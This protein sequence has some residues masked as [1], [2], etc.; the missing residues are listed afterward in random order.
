MDFEIALRDKI[1]NEIMDSLDSIYC[2]FQEGNRISSQ[3]MKLMQYFRDIIDR[4]HFIKYKGQKT[5]KEIL[6][7]TD[8]FE[9]LLTD[10]NLSEMY[11]RT[12]FTEQELLYIKYVKL[13]H[14][15]RNYKNFN[16]GEKY[17]IIDILLR[18][19]ILQEFE[20]Q[21]IE[22][23][24]K[25]MEEQLT[26]GDAKMQP[27]CKHF[28]ELLSDKPYGEHL[29]QDFEQEIEKLVDRYFNDR[30]NCGGYALKIDRCIFPLGRKKSFSQSVSTI[31]DNYSFVQLLGDRKLADDEYL[32]I[33]RANKENTGHHFIRVDDD[34]IVR[35][36]DGNRS[37]KIFNGWSENLENCQEA[38]FAVKKEH[39]MFNYDELKH[40]KEG[41]NFNDT[42][43]QAIE[44]KRNNFSYHGHEFSLKKSSNEEVYVTSNGSIVANILTDGEEHLIEIAEGKEKYVENFSGSITPIIENGHLVNRSQFISQKNFDNNDER[45]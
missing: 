4:Y 9:N 29:S 13:T 31:L 18:K 32:V 34:G 10:E 11:E 30:I 6:Q 17:A 8:E 25:I 19:I 39:Q 5:E 44:N 33:Y 15:C 7:I 12:N 26:Q 36:K 27:T 14:E 23:I 24:V 35:E 16:I 40:K 38:I 37:P 28:L 45:Q 20:Q 21:D 41:L 42:I 22:Q 1:K 43:I 2:N 3:T